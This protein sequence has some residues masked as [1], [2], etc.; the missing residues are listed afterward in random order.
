[1]KFAD[2]TKLEG[3]TGNSVDR[4]LLQMDLIKSE[5][6]QGWPPKGQP[7]LHQGLSWVNF[8]TRKKNTKE[9][10]RKR[11]YYLTRMF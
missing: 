2:A 7:E 6:S 11:A 5:K 9:G 8:N 10:E 3:V 1:M 4:V